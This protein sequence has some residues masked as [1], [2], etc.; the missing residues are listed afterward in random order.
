MS[1]RRTFASWVILITAFYFC[2]PETVLASNCCICSHP[3]VNNGKF[4]LKDIATSCSNLNNSTNADLKQAACVIDQSANPCK[5]IP[6]GQCLNEPIDEV[7]FKLTSIPGYSNSGGASPAPN[8]LKTLD[9]KLNIPL[10]GLIFSAPYQ[11]GNELIVP[12]MAQYLQAFQALLIGLGLIATAIML[13]YGGW[14]YLL[15]GVGLKVQEGKKIMVDAL[16]GLILILGSTVILANINP[17]LTTLTSLR[18]QTV[19]PDPFT[20]GGFGSSAPMQLASAGITPRK[21]LGNLPVPPGEIA[22][23]PPDPNSKFPNY[24]TIPKDCPGRASG[25]RSTGVLSEEVI[26]QYLAYQSKTGIPAAALIANLMTE[27]AGKCA[28]Q[29]MFNDPAA[30]C[31]CKGAKNYCGFYNFGGV[32]CSVGQMPKGANGANCAFPPAYE[33][34]PWTNKVIGSNSCDDG[35]F[36]PNKYWNNIG[37]VGSDCMQVCRNSGSPQ[38]YDCGFSEGG[39]C[40]PQ[41]SYTTNN[42]ADPGRII[43]YKTVQCSRVF[44]DAND[45]LKT[46]EAFIKYCM[47]YNTSVYDFA[48]CIGASSYASEVRKGPILA[49]IIEK[50]CL[51]GSRDASGCQRN[52]SIEEALVKEKIKINF[53]AINP[54]CLEYYPAAPT[55]CKKYS[56][57]KDWESIANKLA[58]KTKGMLLPREL[59]E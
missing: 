9:F 39:K 41:I 51:C 2:L 56:P 44:K 17:N 8:G 35:D 6:A 53:A 20:F 46:E 45:F 40:Y 7:S 25:S 37:A 24:L 38:N 16:I 26:N 42:W 11:E 14:L 31:G 30:A 55:K 54:P 33:T 48:Y 29:G 52:K 15:S 19:K 57:E 4:C 49:D 43:A 1:A 10:P 47:P 32:G 13:M 58:G 3:N 5:K 12:I 21:N 59:P 23:P 28:I 18:L 27:G 50:N 22:P 36:A 34:S